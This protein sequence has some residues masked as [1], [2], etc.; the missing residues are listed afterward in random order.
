MWLP[1]PDPKKSKQ[2]L[3]LNRDDFGLIT[4]WITGHCY[5]ARHQAFMHPEI[6]KKCYLCQE[7]EETPWHLLNDCPAV[8]SK[9]LIPPEPW[10]VAQLLQ[11]I[12]RIR[13]LEVLDYPGPH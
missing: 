12:H 9:N 11:A 2:I 3:A 6:D 8:I 1:T 4:R 13:F 7:A 5:L 10:S